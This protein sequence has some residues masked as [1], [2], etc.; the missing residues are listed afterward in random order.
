MEIVADDLASEATLDLLRIHLQGMHSN[1]PPGQVFALDLTGLRSN[2]V[3]VWT[4]RN[5]DQVWGV[6]ALRQLEDRTGE[7]KSMRTHPHHLRKGVAT[8]LLKHIVAT[9]MQR[10]LTKL[11][12][13]T[14]SGA[15]FDAALTLYRSHGFREGG[16]FGDYQQSD[17]N[18]FL[19]LELG[20]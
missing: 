5:G 13:E 7:V 14:G 11:S 8:A 6:A 20:A 15:A 10:G 1:S 2:D 9:A 4:A 12:L 3:T 18:Q 17:F 19:H 16:P